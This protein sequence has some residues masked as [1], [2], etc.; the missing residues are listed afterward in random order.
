MPSNIQLREIFEAL[1]DGL[2]VAS[3]DGRYIDVNP[4]GCRMMGYVR[5]EFLALQLPDLITQSE[6]PRLPQAIAEMA[7][8]AV[9]RS[10]WLFKRKDGSTFTGELVGGR[11]PDGTFQSIVRDISDRVEREQHERLLKHEAAHRT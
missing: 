8:S 10:E 1:G 11:L 7:D 5:D 2:F 6:L 9:H 3:P 4:A